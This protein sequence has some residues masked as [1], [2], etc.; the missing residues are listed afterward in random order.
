MQELY[1]WPNQLPGISGLINYQEDTSKLE[2]PLH[3][4]IQNIHAKH[5][6][7]M[8]TSSVFC[9]CV[10]GLGWQLRETTWKD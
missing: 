5:G 7:D 6:H 4:S 2:A 9:L 3:E 8:R 1:F 10:H